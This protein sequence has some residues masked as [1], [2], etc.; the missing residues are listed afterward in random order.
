MACRKRD[1]E[2]LLRPPKSAEL[3]NFAAGVAKI[4][5]SGLPGLGER[6]FLATRVSSVGKYS[7][8][9]RFNGIFQ[10]KNHCNLLAYVVDG[11]GDGI[12]RI[13]LLNTAWIQSYEA[14]KHNRTLR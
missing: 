8:S 4:L 14:I 11:I 13:A 9:Y 10:P 2:L 3:K 1:S 5:P 12:R 6:T 7:I